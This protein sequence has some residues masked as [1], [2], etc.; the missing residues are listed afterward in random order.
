MSHWIRRIPTIE[1][2][3]LGLCVGNDLFPGMWMYCLVYLRCVPLRI[4]SEHVVL[5]PL[6]LGMICRIGMDGASLHVLCAASGPVGLAM[7]NVGYGHWDHPVR[8]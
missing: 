4:H 2:L 1:L 8:S 6:G 7:S 5:L 3:V